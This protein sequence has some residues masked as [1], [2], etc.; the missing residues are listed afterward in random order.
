VIEPGKEKTVNTSV[1]L[2]NL[3]AFAVLVPSPASARVFE[4]TVNFVGDCAV[5]ASETNLALKT[6]T[7]LFVATGVELRFVKTKTWDAGDDAIWLRLMNRAPRDLAKQVLG[8]AILD[9]QPRAAL[10]FCDR[11]MEFAY[12]YESK[13]IGVV[14]GYA[15]AHELGHVLRNEPGHSNTGVMTANWKH[16]DIVLM[17][18][19]TIA[20][21]REDRAQIQ[22]RLTAQEQTRHLTARAK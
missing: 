8:V 2:L 15:I 16:T 17:L 14:L 11:V 7:G 18:Q 13:D 9:R 22:A 19:H 20:F 21:S 10:V 5:P 6:A 3:I 12:C 4:V 1:W